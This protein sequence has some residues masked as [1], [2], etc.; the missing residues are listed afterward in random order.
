M[1]IA[2]FEMPDGRIARFEVPEGTTPDQAQ[3]LISQEIAPK[4]AIDEN[5]KSA[6]FS[7]K[8]I[9]LAAGSGSLGGVKTLTDLFGATNTASEKLGEAQQAAQTMKTP[10]RQAEIARREAIK[11]RAK[12]NTW[13][14]IKALAGGFAEAPLEE[15]TEALFSGL[16]VIAGTML[17]PAA[18]VPAGLARLGMAGKAINA[19]R[20]PAAVIGAGMGLGG[21][22][23]Q[24]Y[25]TVKQEALKQGIKPEE[26]ERLAQTASEYSLQN[27]PR[28]LASTATGGLEGV[29]GI[30]SVLGKLGKAAPKADAFKGVKA[31]SYSEAI[32]KNM[33]GE[34]APE[35]IQAATGQVG[36][37]QALNQAGMPTDMMSGVL[38]TALHDALVG[39]VLGAATS[40]AK[41]TEL[42]KTY[43]QDQLAK[44]RETEAV[45]NAGVKA[46]EEKLQRTKDTFKQ[47]ELLGLPAPAKEIAPSIDEPVLVNPLGNITPDELGPEVTGYVNKYRSD[48][49]MP[50][51]KTYSIEDIKDAMTAVNP[52]GEQGALDAILTAKTG[53]SGAEKYTPEDVTNAAVEKNVASDTVGFRD[54]LA[55]TTGNSD[56]STMSPPQL[57]SAFKALKDMPANET[58]AQIVLPEGTNASRFKPAQYKKAVEY[59]GLTFD[60]MG[61]SPLSIDTIVKDIQDSTGLETER[62]ARAL[63]DTAIK[64]NDL[65]ENREVVFRTIKPDTGELISTFRDKARAEAAAK[66]QGL[67]VQEGTLVTVKPA[68]KPEVVKPRATLPEGYDIAET[69][70]VEGEKPTGYNIAPEGRVKPL[71]TVME[72]NDVPA[73]IE[74]LQGLRRKEADKFLQD[75]TKHEGTVKRGRAQLES[76]EARGE[77]DTE[78][79]KKAQAQQARA[80]DVLGRRIISLLD[81]IEEYSAPLTA[82][83]VGKKTVTRKGFTVSKQGQKSGTFPTREAAEE[84]ILADLPDEALDA[85]VSDQKFGGLQNRAVAEQNRRRSGAP[86][87]G[88]KVSEVLEGM[89]PKEKPQSQEAI[90]KTAEL[91]ARLDKMGLQDV[92]LK[93]V[94]AIQAK[95]DGSYEAKLI[96]IALDSEHPVRTMRH[97][98]MHALKELGFFTDA[99]WASLEKMAKNKWVGQYLKSKNAYLPNGKMVTR[100][101]AY[102]LPKDQGGQGLTESEVLEE[103]IADAFGDFDSSKAPPGMLSALLNKLRNFFDALNNYL[104]GR[105]FESYKDVFGK[106]EKGELKAT[107]AEGAGTKFSLAKAEP[108]TIKTRLGVNARDYVSA[109]INPLREAVSKGNAK[110]TTLKDGTQVNLVVGTDQD[111][112]DRGAVVALDQNG[113]VVGQLSFYTAENEDGQRFS[114]D[115]SVSQKLRR[116]GLATALY[117]LAEQNGALIPTLTQPRQAR[118]EEGQAFREARAKGPSQA[119]AWKATPEEQEQA[120]KYSLKNGILP[121]VSEGR[122]DL[123]MQIKPKFSLKTADKYG[124]D[125]VI[126]IPLNKDGTVTVYYHTTKD[127]AVKLNASKTIPS[128]GRSR[129]YLTNESNGGKIL[130]NP[131]SFDQDFDGSTVLLNID[132]S[133]LQVDESYDDGRKDFFVPLAQGDFFNRKMNLASIQKSRKEGIVETFSDADM[134]QRMET[135]LAEYNNLSAAEQKVRLKQARTL[136]KREHNIGTLLSENGKLEKTRVGD[137]GLKEEDKSVASMGL[138]LASAQQI[139]DKLSSCPQSAICQGLCL[140]ETSGGNF[141][142]GGAASEDTRSGI[143]KSAFRAGPRMMQYLKTEALVVHP[144]EFALVLNHEISLFEKWANKETERKKNPDTEKMETSEKEIYQPAIRLNV[145]SDFRPRMWLPIFEAHPDTKF[146]DYTKMNGNPVAP[147]HHLTYSSTGFGQFIDGEKVS[148]KTNNWNAMRGRMDRGDNVAMAFSSKSALPDFIMDEETGTEYQVWDGDNYDARFLDPKPGEDGNLLDRGMIIGLRNKA[149]TLKEKTAAKDTDGFFV[150]YD[151]KRDGKTVNVPH[152]SQFGFKSSAPENR[153]VIPIAKFSLRAAPDTPEFKQFFGDSKVVNADGTPKVMYHGT[154][155]DILAFRGKQADAIFLTD[156]PSFAEKFSKDSAAWMSAHPEEFLSEAEIAQ[157]VKDAIA[158]IRKD[159]KSRPEGKVMIDSLKAGTYA[160]ATAEAQ[161]YLRNTYKQMMPSGPNILPVYVSAQNPFDYKKQAD[162][163]KVLERLDNPDDYFDALIFG[164]WSVIESDEVQKA[165]KDAGFDGFYVQEGGRKNLAVYKPTQIKSATGNI[166]TYDVNNPNIRYSLRSAEDAFDPKEIANH[167]KTPYKGRTKLIDMNIDDFLALSE[168]GEQKSKQALAD[169]RLANG[170]KY[171]SL[172]QMMAYGEGNTLQVEGHEGRHRARALQKA[173]YKTMPVLLTTN[174]RYSE[175]IDPENFDY[176]E[177]FPTKIKAQD[178]ATNPSFTIKFPFTREQAPDDYQPTPAKLSLRNIADEIKSMPNG[179]DIYGSM[180]GTTTTRDEK[181]FI[182]R[183]MDAISPESVSSLRQKA[184]NRYNQL[185]VYDRELVK[186]MG[187][188]PLLADASAEAGALQSDLAAGVTA[189]ALGVHNRKGGIP[190]FKNGI[191][192]VDTSI[193]GPTEIFSPLA[194]MGDPEAYQAYQ[195]WAGAKRGSRFL[196]DGSE[197]VFTP[198]MV[199][200]AKQLCDVDAKGNV[201]GKYPEFAQVQ[202]EWTEYNNGLVQYM[203]DTG[204]LSKEKANEFIRHGDYIPFYRQLDGEKTVGPNIFQSIAGVKPPKAIKH[205]EAPLA[206]FLETVVRNTQAAIQSGM[207]NTAAQRAVDVAV[208]IDQAKR[209]DAQSSAPD[210]V[211]VLRN[212]NPVSYQTADPLF[213]EAVKSLNL[214]ELPFLSILAGPSNLLRN[215]VTKDPGFMLVNLMRDSMSA[216]VTSGNNMLP[217]VDTI[218]NFGRAIQGTDPAYQAL[219]NAGIGGGYEFSQN[220]EASGEALAKDLRKKTGTQTGFEKAAKP[221]TSLWDTLEKGTEASDFAT[222]MAVYKDVLARTGNEA[223]ALFRALEVMNFNRKGS[224]AVVRIITAAIPFL[225]ARMQGLDVFYRAAFGRMGNV[226]PKAIQRSFFIRGATMASLSVMYWAAT[227]DDDDYKKQEQETK[228]NNWLIPSLGIKIAIP[229]EVGVLFKVIPERIAAYAF[230]N[231]TGKDFAKSMGRQIESTFAVSYLPQVIQPLDEART[232][233]S[234]YTGRPIVGQGLESVAPQYQIGPNTTGVAQ[235]LGKE[236]KASP[237]KIDHVIQGYTGTMGMYLVNLI[238]AVCGVNSNSP[239]ADKRFEQLPFFKRFMIDKEARGTVTSYFELKHAVDETVR[240]YNLLER[241]GKAEEL[242]E[243]TRENAKMLMTRDFVSSM[244]KDLKEINEMTIAVRNSPMSGEAKKDALTALTRAANGLTAKI[245]NVRKAVE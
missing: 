193:K 197:K 227:H 119:N 70:F 232:N 85:L 201:S 177:T 220:I 137:Y 78:G 160:D 40:P 139:T 239:K 35:F 159:Y 124:I 233:Y 188:A 51:L 235:W 46:E 15:T 75:V 176:R 185:S 202:K 76:M 48:N 183:M 182:E 28:Q 107:K 146:Y 81:R 171:T 89:E 136:L 155:Q 24:D 68:V 17:A 18:A 228:D 180:K 217:I 86:T 213:I 121:Y 208:Q 230:G 71:A 199:N 191:T 59:V 222:R 105:G 234:R 122:L 52:K 32:L 31:P 99:Q 143:E 216:Y 145:T 175:Q 218:K 231:D 200:Y 60:E 189:A 26:A 73:K 195:F 57:Y 20:S 245:Q 148:H 223:E 103:A 184:L 241:S 242:G 120:E 92:G 21:Q 94:E 207:K 47:P 133:L 152:Q 156:D 130:N 66:K 54:F 128:E 206:D 95:A 34:A 50:K 210:T 6:P 5:A 110:L 111:E 80:E 211:T 102:T 117:D 181:G 209:L 192:T 126:G 144:E 178:K 161:E 39:G 163:D 116:Q 72:E 33:A 114:P 104:A 173:G 90:E 55:R 41:M 154:G 11:E 10:E 190:V 65:A 77:L 29:L 224:S 174:I 214:P 63:L 87:T 22:K 64:N 131:G 43:V 38:S 19:A 100:Y 112:N 83:P 194:A 158:A 62:D 44:E 132:P 179:K 172:P 138:G 198:A 49:G 149:S 2:R 244:D 79:Y 25:E 118:T 27:A 125:P 215:L 42:R 134:A 226:D 69:A 167:A 45:I 36:S 151:P 53:Y 142:Y 106:I 96:Q 113:N 127:L 229:F 61:G 14:E 30:E 135:A 240:T 67:N 205:G 129:I 84:S 221:F 9:A 56:L 170:D 16:P 196:K 164:E 101:E 74:R 91:R 108:V 4:P 150:D 166:G 187:G 169:E 204:V 225:N 165:I 168:E 1:P 37:N 162:R 58:G 97:E 147:N 7:F 238:D 203:V 98:A 93:I 115:V 109:Y 8:N 243:Y 13:E 23:G 140:G 212:G 219:L 141:L 157:G 236:L 237:L 3:Q 186:K 153:K 88:K 123:P 82:K 12:G